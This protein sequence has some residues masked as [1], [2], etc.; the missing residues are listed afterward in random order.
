MTT[1]T[2]HNQST[3]ETLKKSIAL[4]FSRGGGGPDPLSPSM[5]P[6]MES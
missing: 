1:N 2:G 3:I 6:G 4:W 5:D